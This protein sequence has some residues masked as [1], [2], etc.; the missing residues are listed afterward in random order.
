MKI[1][2]LIKLVE[3]LRKECPWD[4]EQ[5]LDSL[6]NNVIEES[7]E[8]IEAIEDNDVSSIKE[9]IGDILFLGFFLAKIFEEEKDIGF[10]EL[11]LS[12]VKKYKDKHPH[13]FK[14]ENFPDQ[15]AVLRFWQKTKKDIFAGISKVL[16]AL[17]AAKII[18]ERA[19]KLGFDWETHKGPLEKINEEIKEIEKSSKTEDVFEEV[20][21]LLFACV[22]LARHLSVD[23]EDALRYANK[24]FVKRFRKVMEELKKRGKDIEV[25]D[26]EEM[27]K[28]WDEIKKREG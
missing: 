20:G 18:Q 8:L 11:I 19:S 3:T 13:V 14:E 25:T 7:Y 22:N 17:L 1:Y 16:P 12:T 28:I 9:E 4:R 10:D 26:L 2:D 21:D 15:D 5:T 6:K 23:P 24:K 27:D